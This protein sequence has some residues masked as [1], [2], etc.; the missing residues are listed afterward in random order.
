MVF[1]ADTDFSDPWGYITV[2]FY[3]L[4]I[5]SIVLFFRRTNRV[6]EFFKKHKAAKAIAIIA[7]VIVAI[8]TILFIA[9]Y[10]LYMSGY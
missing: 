9:G 2:L 1:F 7:V 4:V 6:N 5:A 10:L 8:Y 3:L